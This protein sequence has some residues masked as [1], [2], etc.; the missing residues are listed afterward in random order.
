[1]YSLR[2]RVFL[3]EQAQKQLVSPKS[4]E[5]CFSIDIKFVDVIS[6]GS[7][8]KIISEMLCAAGIHLWSHG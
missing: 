6:K 5:A 4:L 3:M 8:R 2:A 1:M 7:T